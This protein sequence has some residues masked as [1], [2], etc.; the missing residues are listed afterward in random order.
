M[1]TSD[2]DAATTSTRRQGAAEEQGNAM[3]KN[4]ATPADTVDGGHL[5]IQSSRK[6]TIIAPD[7]GRI[8]ARRHW[9]R[10]ASTGRGSDDQ[11]R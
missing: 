9:C 10:S 7:Q 1:S 5:E 2:E 3:T 4:E 6:S 11:K 8:M